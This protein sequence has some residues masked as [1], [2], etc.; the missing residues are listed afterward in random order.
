MPALGPLVLLKSRDP[1]EQQ[2]KK[3]GCKMISSQ[4]T[5]GL[6]LVERITNQKV[7]V[8]LYSLSS[9]VFNFSST[10]PDSNSLYLQT[11]KIIIP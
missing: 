3:L 6:M 2:E 4:D 1:S 5:E 11:L 10:D 9:V 8:S 7:F